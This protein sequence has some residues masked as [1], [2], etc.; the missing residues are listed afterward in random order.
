MIEPHPQL[1]W[2]GR[3]LAVAGLFFVVRVAAGHAD[4][5][6]AY[7]ERADAWIALAAATIPALLAL[8]VVF[9]AWRQ[10]LEWLGERVGTRDAFVCYGYSNISKYVPGNV[11]HLLSRQLLGARLGL[12][13]RVLAGSSVLELGLISAVAAAVAL[14]ILSP[15]LAPV[16]TLA[17][18]VAI[19][20]VLRYRRA[21]R[22]WIQRRLGIEIGPARHLAAALLAYV[23][24][25]AL[26][27]LTLLAILAPTGAA[28]PGLLP[29]LIAVAGAAFVAGFVV[30]GAPAGLGVRESVMLLLLNPAV[31][32]PQALWATLASRIS[33]TCADLLLFGTALALGRGRRC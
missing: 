28:G 21:A 20:A 9:W 13:H 4:R 11:F 26:M 16:A 25:F 22:A 27:G 5:L 14:A 8:M 24:F 2:I 10:L 33:W 31:G 23:V 30:P 19:A 29:S 18:A 32:E 7:L 12:S 3:I 17:V 15:A 1:K 6:V